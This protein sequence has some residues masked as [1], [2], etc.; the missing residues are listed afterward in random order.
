MAENNQLENASVNKLH[1]NE[2]IEVFY[3]MWI[4]GVNLKCLNIREIIWKN[5]TTKKGR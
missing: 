5:S 3:T 4:K 2:P 1:S